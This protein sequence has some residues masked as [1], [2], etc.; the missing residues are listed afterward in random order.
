ML[1]RGIPTTPLAPTV[2]T[3]KLKW[4]MTV[5]PPLDGVLNVELHVAHVVAT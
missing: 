5:T 2:G 3:L 1:L 4:A